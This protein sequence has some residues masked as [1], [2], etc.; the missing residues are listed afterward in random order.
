MYLIPVRSEVAGV[1]AALLDGRRPVTDVNCIIGEHDGAIL[2]GQS[3]LAKFRSNRR[4]VQRKPG[5]DPWRRSAQADKLGMGS[6]RAVRRWAS[7]QN[8]IAPRNP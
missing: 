7:G 3:F 5:S 1:S 4:R 2:L 8:P 6:D